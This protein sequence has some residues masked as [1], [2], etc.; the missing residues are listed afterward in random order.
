[1][2]VAHIAKFVGKKQEIL[3]QIPKKKYLKISIKIWKI[4]FQL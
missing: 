1:M 2:T 3:K 4:D